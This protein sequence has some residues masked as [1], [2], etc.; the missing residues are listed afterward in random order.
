MLRNFNAVVRVGLHR[1][2]RT[3][4]VME[5]NTGLSGSLEQGKVHAL[6]DVNF[7]GD[8]D[9]N[10]KT[11]PAGATMKDG[12]TF[13]VRAGAGV[14]V[15]VIDDLR[16]GAEAFS[17]IGLS[18][19]P[20]GSEKTWVIAGPNASWTHGRFWMSAMYGIGISNIGT[21]PRVQWG[22]AF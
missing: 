10:D 12:S 16:F 17:V 3:R 22:I 8:V 5:F 19:P 13:E 15:E 21:A 4:D 11:E 7:V 2:I 14:S 9:F 20:M 18:T 1:V 6:A